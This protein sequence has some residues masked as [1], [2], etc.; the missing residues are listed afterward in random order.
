MFDVQQYEYLPT[1][2]LAGIRLVINDQGA[3]VFPSTEGLY[4]A[5][6]LS[7]SI[8]LRLV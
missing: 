6:G 8:A 7:T 2:P 5:P 3:N 4:A 1:T